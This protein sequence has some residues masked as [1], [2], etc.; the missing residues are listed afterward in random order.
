QNHRQHQ[1][2]HLPYSDDD[3]ADQSPSH[4]SLGRRSHTLGAPAPASSMWGD[5]QPHHPS[6]SRGSPDDST[7]VYSPHIPSASPTA[8]AADAA[9]DSEPPPFLPNAS[10]RQLQLANND[11]RVA[12]FP[13]HFSSSASSLAS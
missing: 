10:R 3:E 2:Q 1:Q 4:S 7:Y 9:F 11:N 12:V 6:A 13:R 5:R 8:V